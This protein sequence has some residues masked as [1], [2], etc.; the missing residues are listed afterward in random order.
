MSFATR[1]YLVAETRKT[2]YKT[3]KTL[4]RAKPTAKEVATASPAAPKSATKKGKGVGKQQA[5]QASQTAPTTTA[6][7]GNTLL[8]EQPAT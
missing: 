4:E 6:F 3:P 5:E 2:I 1:Q 8:L 7:E